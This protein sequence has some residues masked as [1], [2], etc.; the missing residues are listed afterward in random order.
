M[1]LLLL[2]HFFIY[3]QVYTLFVPTPPSSP[4][5]QAEP[6]LQFCWREYLREQEKHIV[7]ASLR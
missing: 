3:L 7:F 5:C 2:C 1:F 6:L 4:Y